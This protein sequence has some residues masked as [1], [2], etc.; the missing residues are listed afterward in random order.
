MARG[1]TSG[2]EREEQREKDEKRTGAGPSNH[3]RER[4]PPAMISR[5]ASE[6]PW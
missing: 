6:V 2:G 1:Q 4:M 3:D 5:C